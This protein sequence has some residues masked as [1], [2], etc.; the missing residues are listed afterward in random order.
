MAKKPVGVTLRKPPPANLDAFVANDSHI[1]ELARPEV[2]VHSPRGNELREMTV[3]L[4]TD[5]ARKLALYC[6][7]ADRDP[8]KVLSEILERELSANEPEV[9]V[10]PIS[11]WERL[12]ANVIEAVRSRLAF[13]L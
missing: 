12:R 7:D 2:V 10:A 5:V 6:H 8:N 9:E 1:R 3:Y 13:G 4:P 11:L